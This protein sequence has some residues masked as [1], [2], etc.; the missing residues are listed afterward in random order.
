MEQDKPVSFPGSKK[1]KGGKINRKEDRWRCGQEI[2]EKA[3]A[4]L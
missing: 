3:K 1:T 4:A 2:G